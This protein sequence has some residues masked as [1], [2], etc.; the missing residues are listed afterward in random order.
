MHVHRE[1][2]SYG[3]MGWMIIV[4]TMLE[5]FPWTAWNTSAIRPLTPM[6][7]IEQILVPTTAL[8]LITEDLSVL[9][10]NLDPLET[11]QASGQYGSLIFPYDDQED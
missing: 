2:H 4:Q 7:A 9:A 1:S 3:E 8:S 11:M 10:K 6:Q 5:L